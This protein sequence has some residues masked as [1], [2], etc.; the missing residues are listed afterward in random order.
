MS[1]EAIIANTADINNLTTT[2]EFASS[3][4]RTANEKVVD[5]WDNK[6]IVI[7]FTTTTDDGISV[8]ERVFEKG[9]LE[10]MAELFRIVVSCHINVADK[11]VFN[12]KGFKAT[13]F[14]SKT[15]EPKTTIAIAFV[16]NTKWGEDEDEYI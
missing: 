10:D 16:S 6:K 3:F 13:G 11:I 15:D 2:E 14:M 7:R 1:L 12:H 8:D 5:I 4:I 9:S